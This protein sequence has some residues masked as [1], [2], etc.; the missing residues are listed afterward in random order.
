MLACFSLTGFL[1]RT[2]GKIESDMREYVWTK[3]W[4]DPR[5]SSVTG[6]TIA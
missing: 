1:V 2:R 5:K 3:K 6:T 4:T